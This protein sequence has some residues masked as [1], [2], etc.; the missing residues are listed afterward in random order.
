MI[1]CIFALWP[2]TFF[3]VSLTFNYF[4]W[5][6]SQFCRLLF[7]VSSE[8]VERSK[9]TPELRFGGFD[10]RS[11]TRQWWESHEFS[12]PSAWR[13]RRLLTDVWIHGPRH[14]ET[15]SKAATGSWP[16]GFKRDE[17]II[18]LN[19]ACSVSFL[20]VRCLHTSRMS[21]RGG[22]IGCV[23]PAWNIYFT[24][25]AIISGLIFASLQ[26]VFP[27]HQTP[28]TAPKI[29]IRFLRSGSEVWGSFGMLVMAD[30]SAGVL[31]SEYLMVLMSRKIQG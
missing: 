27:L 2:V 5:C 1:V 22:I 9:S 23:A 17:S 21:D 15:A 11:R 26:S 29:C 3:F 13:G 18:W 14:R 24:P 28:V 6:V 20:S 31:F 19:F 8:C 7:Y 12:P 25:C 16:S 30:P 4:H 10:V